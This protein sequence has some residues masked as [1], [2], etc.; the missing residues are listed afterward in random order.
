VL[1]PDRIKEI[2][3]KYELTEEDEKIVDEI[4]ERWETLVG[5]TLQKIKVVNELIADSPHIRK[6][7]KAMLE[8]NVEFASKVWS[9][10]IARPDGR[11]R[12]NIIEICQEECTKGGKHKLKTDENVAWC[13]KCGNQWLIG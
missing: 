2:C 4:L 3:R 1:G 12:Y 11:G 8:I 10:N 13:E 7:T 9:G 5:Q 6:I